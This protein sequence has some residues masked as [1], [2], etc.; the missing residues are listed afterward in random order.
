[1]TVTFRKERHCCSLMSVNPINAPRAT[2]V[3]ALDEPR[4]AGLLVR[5]DRE[6]NRNTE[7]HP[8][9]P[10][11]SVTRSATAAIMNADASSTTLNLMTVDH[12][13]YGQ[14]AKNQ[15]GQIWFAMAH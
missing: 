7:L 12:A 3:R 11:R 15:R 9:V 2:L 6:I 10:W 13:R 5:V 4:G 1:A 14:N 8:L